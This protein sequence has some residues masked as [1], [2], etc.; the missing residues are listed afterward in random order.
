MTYV[1]PY[2]SELDESI[3][4]AERVING[5][6]MNTEWWKA[7]RADLLRRMIRHQLLEFDRN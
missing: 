1:C 7:Y 4:H 6:S 3:K 2:L 5:S